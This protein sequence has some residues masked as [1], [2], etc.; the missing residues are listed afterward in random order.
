MNELIIST[1]QTP[2]IV[3]FDNFGEVKAELEE[4]VAERFTHAEYDSFLI[5]K[6]C[7]KQGESL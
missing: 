3:T 2:G 4:Y 7:S 6:K 5:V 1:R